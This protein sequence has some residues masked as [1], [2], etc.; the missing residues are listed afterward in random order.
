MHDANKINRI[1]YD[2]FPSESVNSLKLEAVIED[3][4]QDR[5]CF[6]VSGHIIP[7]AKEITIKV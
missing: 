3:L 4:A 5:Y 6:S 2:C 1:I 7:E